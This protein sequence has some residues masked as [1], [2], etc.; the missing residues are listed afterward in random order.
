MN[1]SRYLIILLI[2]ALTMSLI[3]P[4]FSA[5]PT[6]LK[7]KYITGT[8]YSDNNYNGKLN[9]GEKGIAGITVKLYNPLTKKYTS[10]KTNSKG[11]Y[12]FTVYAQ[13]TYTI[14]PVLSSPYAFS[15]KKS[16]AVKAGT[17][18]ATYVNNFF[19]FKAGEVIGMAYA[20]WDHNGKLSAGDGG[21]Y[22][23]DKLG[24]PWNTQKMTVTLVGPSGTLK[25][26]INKTGR[27]D[28]T[29]LKPGT[30][31]ISASML[32]PV[33][34]SPSDE[35]WFIDQTGKYAVTVNAGQKVNVTSSKG[36]FALGFTS[37]A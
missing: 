5:T 8:V 9:T 28:F 23:S 11:V 21:I 26:T 29:G 2:I 14:T 10:V 12:K 27:F 31:K 22:I 37:M 18:T 30:Y 1:I 24:Y 20:D 17:A 4:A 16:V 34:K 35:Y 13:T 33:E 19:I 15:G 25:Q 6:A 32:M 3:A 36:L 7:P